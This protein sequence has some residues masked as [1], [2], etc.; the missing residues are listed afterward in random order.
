MEDLFRL[1]KTC[2]QVGKNINHIQ[3]LCKKHKD[4]KGKMKKVLRKES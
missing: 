2:W 1:D 3:L 4:E